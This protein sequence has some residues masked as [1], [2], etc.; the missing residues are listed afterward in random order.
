MAIGAAQVVVLG[1]LGLVAWP[2]ARAR[3]MLW[4]ARAANGLG[5]V[6]WMPRLTLTGY[7]TRHAA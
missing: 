6:F 2:F 3:A 7:G 1:T 5:K 4:L